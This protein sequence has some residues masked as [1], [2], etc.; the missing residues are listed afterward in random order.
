[1]QVGQASKSKQSILNCPFLLALEDLRKSG[2]LVKGSVRV[3]V[4]VRGKVR[5]GEGK[6]QGQGQGHRES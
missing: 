6:G 1:M 2:V 5:M 3:R 4:R